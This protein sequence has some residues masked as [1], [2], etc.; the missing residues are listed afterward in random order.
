MV[1]SNRT[2]LRPVRSAA[3]PA[4]ASVEASDP[5]IQ[6][7][8]Q[9]HV[10]VQLGDRSHVWSGNELKDVDPVGS[11]KHVGIQR[12]GATTF[13][14]D[15]NAAGGFATAAFPEVHITS[16]KAYYEM[17]IL[18]APKDCPTTPQ[19]Q[20]GWATDA[21]LETSKKDRTVD[22]VGIGDDAEGQS[23]GFD[24]MRMGVIYKDGGTPALPLGVMPWDSGINA[25]KEGSVVGVAIDLD[26]GE[27]F[28]GVD[29]RWS[30][31]FWWQPGPGCVGGVIPASTGLCVKMELVLRPDGSRPPPGEGFTTFAEAAENKLRSERP[32]T[33]SLS[34]PHTVKRTFDESTP[35]PPKYP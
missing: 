30:K 32:I 28:F 6:V 7:S 9:V 14:L 29:G 4:K 31:G 16:G 22:D 34:F 13:V 35:W 26:R 1:I 2:H 3:L 23:F 25:A 12:T 21:Y 15:H 24:P 11:G 10:D 27:A 33:C 8:V 20:I 5:G 19:A 17:R 18:E